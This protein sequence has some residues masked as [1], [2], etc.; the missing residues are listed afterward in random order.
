M[1][2]QTQNGC[3]F[4][5]AICSS[6]SEE[7]NS[8]L[9]LHDMNNCV[10]R[11]TRDGRLSNIEEHYHTITSELRNS[12]IYAAKAGIKNIIPL[13]PHLW[14]GTTEHPL[15]ISVNSNSGN[16][17]DVRDVI[18]FR[19]ED[20]DQSIWQ[21][22]LSC[23]WNHRALKHSRLSNSIDFGL[24]W[25][26]HPCSQEYWNDILPIMNVL[27]HY[28]G[29]PWRDFPEK[30]T[31]IYRP[32]LIAFMNELRRLANQYMDVPQ[33]L[34]EYVVGR[35][36]FYKIIG[37]PG[38]QRTDIQAYNLHNTLNIRDRGLRPITTIERVRGG[39]PTRI[40]DISF[41]RNSNNTISIIMDEGWQ[42]TFRIHNADENIQSSLK[43]D[44]NFVGNPF[45]SFSERWN[46]TY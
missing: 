13:E 43:F 5:Y 6:L 4:E 27:E 23:K 7:I 28:H 45:A 8:W 21:I 40:V 33:K 19:H 10:I 44:I 14:S 34:T 11:L 17:G 35:F 24:L 42:F 25:L 46:R 41:R 26:D 20:P 16:L 18:L 29:S 30:S 2:N 37:L 36:D 39:L 3:A 32:I 9:S 31:R 22:G 1:P 12:M 38:R 15:E